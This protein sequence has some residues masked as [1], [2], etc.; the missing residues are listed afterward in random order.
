MRPLKSIGSSFRSTDLQSAPREL[1]N[2]TGVGL[3][4]SGSVFS[5][6]LIGLARLPKSP[7]YSA[8]PLWNRATD[9]GEA[10]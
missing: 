10:G 6:L 2:R 9:E 5:S 7:R 1:S 4:D 8:L 3:P